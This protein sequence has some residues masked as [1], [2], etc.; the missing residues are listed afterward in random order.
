MAFLRCP[1]LFNI[2]V[3]GQERSDWKNPIQDLALHYITKG[4]REVW[5]KNPIQ[6]PALQYISK[7]TREVWL[8][9]PIQ[10]PAL[11]YISNLSKGTREVWLKKPIQDPA[12]QY[13][14]VIWVRGQ[15]R[16]DFNL[17]EKP[18]T[19]RPLPQCIVYHRIRSIFVLTFEHRK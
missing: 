14:S 15:E 3:R 19:R 7:G 17:I 9:N 12:L 1:R 8:K 6:D 5:L 4:T 11:Q 18:H 10:D 16:S 2:S 13:I